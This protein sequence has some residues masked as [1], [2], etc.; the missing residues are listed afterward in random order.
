MQLHDI[1]SN[2]KKKK[3]IGRGGK[4]GTYSGK[5]MKGQKSRSGHNFEPVIR[6]LIKSYPKLR[7][8]R[9]KATKII[10]EVN[11][12]II[13]KFFKDG[14]VVTPTA[15]LEKKLIRREFG[16]TPNAKILGTGEITKKISFK[17]VL[18]SIPAKIKIEKAG[19]TVEAFSIKPVIEDKKMGKKAKRVAK[20]TIEKK[21]K[22]IKIA[23]KKAAKKT[24]KKVEKKEVKKET[25]KETKK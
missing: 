13:E 22:E 17:E 14:D 25:K 7:G 15:L 5:G 19:G 6:E 12:S 4:R 24:G 10:A 20:K 9:N 21:E 18:V 8:Y 3:R 16:R 23:E 1:Q 11:L 2:N